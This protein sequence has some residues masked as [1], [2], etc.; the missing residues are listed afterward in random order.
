MKSKKF[1]IIH[2]TIDDVYYLK[3]RFGNTYDDLIVDKAYQLAV[4]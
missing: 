3:E 4:F 2:M 1:T